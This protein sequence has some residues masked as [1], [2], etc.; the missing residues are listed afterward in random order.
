MSLYGPRIQPDINI[1]KVAKFSYKS[2]H[3][4]CFLVITTRLGTTLWAL[5][6]FQA[7]V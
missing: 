3:K 5:T 4:F 2:L 6:L 7:P 1:K